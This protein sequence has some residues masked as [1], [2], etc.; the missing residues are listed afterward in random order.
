ME[1]YKNSDDLRDIAVLRGTANRY[2]YLLRQ[3][4]QL[5]QLQIQRYKM[6]DEKMGAELT[7]LTTR[8]NNFNKKPLD[9]KTFN[10]NNNGLIHSSMVN[11]NKFDIGDKV[12]SQDVT[13]GTV[14]RKIESSMNFQVVQGY[15]KKKQKEKERD[16]KDTYVGDEAQVKCGILT[17]KYSIKHGILLTE[18]SLN[19]KVN[20]EKMTQIM[21]E[22]LNA[23]A[24]DM[25]IQT[26]L[27]LWLSG[28]IFGIV[29]DTGDDVSVDC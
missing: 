13:Q 28:R 21:F 9:I 19:P 1:K 11:N 7:I 5:K 22:T 20:R 26:V 10:V 6:L 16:R 25:V 24:L 29:L 17:L 4:Q 14:R 12:K 27:F 23:A 18:A 3:Q 2:Y 8:L 15:G